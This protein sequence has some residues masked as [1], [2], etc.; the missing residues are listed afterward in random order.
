MQEEGLDAIANGEA[1]KRDF[2]SKFYLGEEA[3]NTEG[4]LSRVTFKLTKNMI[5]QNTSRNLEIPQIS[6]LGVVKL[7]RN[8]AYFS[9]GGINEVLRPSGA[10]KIAAGR[11]VL[12]SDMQEDIRTITSEKIEDLM[13]TETTIEGEYLGNHP[14]SQLPITMRSGR[15]GKYLQVGDESTPKAER[16]T[17]SVPTY[18][19]LSNYW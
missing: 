5:D 17:K 4:L 18:L 16:F 7:S 6:H 2:L 13:T 1:N 9:S 11:W 14:A 3:D 12:P 10:Q 8:G 19:D 15:W